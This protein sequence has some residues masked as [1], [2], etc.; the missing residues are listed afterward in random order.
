MTDEEFTEDERLPY[1]VELWPASLSLADYL[2]ERAKD[3]R[4]KACL[5]LGCGLG[6]TALV[7][8]WLG[9][10]VLAADYEPKAFP[11]AKQNAIVNEVPQPGWL[12]MD[13]RHPAVRPASLDFI[14][15][16]DI[17]YEK[18]FVDP[19]MNFLEYA[20][21]PGGTV[22]LAEPGR[23]VYDF[24]KARLLK[25]GWASC[26]V[27]KEAVEPLHIQASKVHVNLWELKKDRG[28]HA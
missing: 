21:A 24:F 12:L 28:S 1:W 5:D 11:Y 17:M 14:W 7:A 26:C 16:G 15:G 27:K 18:R 8:S 20:L 13:W 25:S 22:W 4:G 2:H 10:T 6:L 9:A 19:V 23:N 3:I